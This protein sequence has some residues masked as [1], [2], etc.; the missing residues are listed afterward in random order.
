MVNFQPQYFLKRW[1]LQLRHAFDRNWMK[2]LKDRT[3]EE[4]RFLWP[5]TRKGLPNRRSQSIFVE[6][7]FINKHFTALNVGWKTPLFI[8]K[9]EECWE[10]VIECLI[11]LRTASLDEKSDP[12]VGI[13]MVER[14][15]ERSYVWVRERL[16]ERSLTIGFK[17][18]S[19]FY[20]HL[21]TPKYKM[22]L[23]HYYN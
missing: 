9:E 2:G 19:T 14:F 17:S 8:S 23:F 18:T 22:S 5:V 4:M 11:S 10:L 1:L 21:H 7:R 3:H 15:F 13:P 6:E 20:T 12:K 16:R